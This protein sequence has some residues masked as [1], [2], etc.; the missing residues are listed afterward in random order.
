MKFSNKDTERI[1]GVVAA[2]AA[3]GAADAR[4]KLVAAVTGQEVAGA[5]L[6][7]ADLAISGEDLKDAGVP[8]GPQMGKLLKLLLELV[9]DDPSLNRREKLLARL[10]APPETR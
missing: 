5:P 7:V 6:T 2:L 8:A 4:A 10:P 1:A 3:M 9:L